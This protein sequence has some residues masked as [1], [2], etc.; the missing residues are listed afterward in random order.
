MPFG[1]CARI[2]L[3][4]APLAEI[5]L[6]ELLARYVK[7]LVAG[8]VEGSDKALEYKA[9]DVRAPTNDI[10]SGRMVRDRSC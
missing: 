2:Y 9:M 4:P 7:H 1:S 6:D 10:E 5:V 8:L 3:V